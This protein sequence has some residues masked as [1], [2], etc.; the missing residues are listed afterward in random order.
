[1]LEII[2]ASL[3][4]ML[5]S[6][7]GVVSVWKKLGKIIE[8]NLHFLV[9]FSA[10]VFLFVT[11]NLGLETIE[12]AEK[13]IWGLVW[14]FAGA[15]GLWLIFKFLPSFH[16]HHDS[17]LEPHTH[18]SIDTR[19][20]ILADG[21]HNIGDGLLLAA[22]FTVSTTLGLITTLS[23]FAHEIIQEISEFFVMRESGYSVKKALL[24]N[25]LVSGTI[26]VGSLGGF[27]LL[28]TF[29]KIEVPLLGIATGSF[30]MVVIQDLVP[31]S[32]RSVSKQHLVKHLGW[33]L[34]GLFIMILVGLV[35]PSH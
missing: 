2:L 12:H 27:F 32:V 15:L 31:H 18:S 3:V 14:I 22:S 34:L 9:S 29:E 16:H 24:T 28:E 11:Y 35:S 23:I 25:F 21:I 5:A 6:L 10:G 26:L 1:M 19:R 33:F 4:I 8:K 13:I 7:V 30:L 20:I 17:E